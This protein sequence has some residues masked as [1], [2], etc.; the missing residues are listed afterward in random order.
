MPTAGSTALADLIAGLTTDGLTSKIDRLWVFA[1]PTEVE[2]LVDVIAAAQATTVGSPTFVANRGYTGQDS[3]S[4]TKY[5]TTTFNPSTA[6]GSYS[7]NSA[8]ISQWQVN[9]VMGSGGGGIAIGNRHSGGSESVIYAPY[10]DGNVYARINDGGGS[11]AET[12]YNHFYLLNRDSST[13]TQLYRDGSLFASPANTSNTL[14]N[15]VF[16]ILAENTDGTAQEGTSNQIAAVSAGGSLNGTEAGN[17]YT[18]LRTYMTAV[19]VP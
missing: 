2:A 17:F 3:S 4:P 13:T 12:S 19:G 10:T 18:R 16:Y 8:H 9:N 7:L 5:I 6:G 1:Q 11:T 14:D 15:L